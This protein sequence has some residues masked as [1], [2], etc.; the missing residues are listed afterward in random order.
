MSP[1]KHIQQLRG[2]FTGQFGQGI[3][4]R[5]GGIQGIHLLIPLQGGLPGLAGFFGLDDVG[6]FR[7]IDQGLSRVDGIRRGVVLLVSCQGILISQEMGAALL[8][9]S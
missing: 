3:E 2:V 6:L 4:L 5:H 9:Q 8:N 7:Y 1:I